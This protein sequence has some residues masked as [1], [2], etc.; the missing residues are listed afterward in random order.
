[1]QQGCL[2]TLFHGRTSVDPDR[3]VFL[4]SLGRRGVRGS[5]TVTDENFLFFM[6]N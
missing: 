4:H 2:L 5:G 3:N 6:Y 1:M